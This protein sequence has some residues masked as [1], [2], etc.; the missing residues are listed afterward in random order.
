MNSLFLSSDIFVFSSYADSLPIAL[1]EA[2]SNECFIITS[3]F[4]GIYSIFRPGLD[5]FIY[6]KYSAKQ[7]ADAISRALKLDSGRQIYIDSFK[8]LLKKRFT[9]KVMAG[10]TYKYYKE[11]IK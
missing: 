1:L 8:L 6:E 5:G 11:I 4:T 3:D 2:G 10:N 9:S 7:L